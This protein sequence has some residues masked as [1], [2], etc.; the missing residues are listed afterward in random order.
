MPARGSAGIAQHDHAGIDEKSAIAI[1]GKARKPVEVGR[2]SRRPPAAARPANRSAIAT[3]CG[4]GSGRWSRRCVGSRDAAK[5]RRARRR[6]AKCV[7]ARSVRDDATRSAGSPVR[8]ARLHPRS[9]PDDRTARPAVRDPATQRPQAPR[10]LPRQALQSTPRGPPV[11]PADCFRDLKSRGK[12]IR[13][14]SRQTILAS[15][16]NGSSGSAGEGAR[17]EHAQACNREPFRAR[18]L[19]AAGA[20]AIAPVGACTGIEQHRDDGEIEGGTRLCA[21]YP[22]TRLSP[23]FRPKDRRRTC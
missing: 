11:R 21:P 3:A 19:H 23:R 8:A 18:D 6:R 12:I 20:V 9:T 5:C 17:L 16:R 15:A 13:G 10:A 22:A 1:F 7:P 14:E 4:T 2:L